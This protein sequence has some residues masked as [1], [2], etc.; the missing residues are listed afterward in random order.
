[1]STLYLDA[2]SSSMSDEYADLASRIA[3]RTAVCEGTL[4]ISTFGE[5]SGQTVTLLD[6]SF[7][8]EAP[9]ENAKKRKQQQLAKDAAA[10]VR[11]KFAAAAADTSS[12]ATDVIGVLRLVGEAQAQRPDAVHEVI[13]A[14]DGVTNVG[15]DPAAAL[16]REAAL[17]LAEQ[18]KVPDLSGVH[19]T[20]A[21]I[22]RTTTPLPS[23]TVEQISVFWERVCERTNAASCTV[24]TQWKG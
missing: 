20:F 19:L 7:S 17:G 9:T 1:M 2:T 6:Q 24:A 15:V 11:D 16:S 23:A 3:T 5:S 13:L 14:T 10:T 18:V 4:A 22:G 12:S 8:V 21:G